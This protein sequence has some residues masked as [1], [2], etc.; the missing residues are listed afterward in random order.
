MPQTNVWLPDLALQNGF[1]SLKGLGSSFLYVNILQNGTITWK[2]YQIFESACDVDVLYFPFDATTCHLKFVI[3][4][5]TVDLVKISTGSNGLNMDLFQE[6]SQW[7]I[8]STS[9][10]NYE[11]TTTSGVMFSLLMK[12]KPLFYL[13]N[14]LIPVIMLAVLNVFVFV[15]PAS[16]G[17][18]SAFSVTA[19]LAFVVF[20]TII[21]TELPQNSRKLSLFDGYLF[22][23]TLLSTVI[24]VVTL[25]Q[26]RLFNRDENR[27]IPN[28][29]HNMVCCVHK[30]RCKICIGKGHVAFDAEQRR[31]KEREVTWA[32]VCNSLDFIF[33]WMFLLLILLLTIVCITITSLA[34][35]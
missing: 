21:S 7:S 17:E 30:L 8:L 27:P 23:M 33:F 18:K 32:G 31:R 4:S 20:L 5:N 16:S 12:R 1:K 10:T 35:A 28:T 24:V 2:P 14:I 6:S 19:F 15:L 11:T 3:W 26:L 29:L 22:L 13:L 34:S 9:T 25:M